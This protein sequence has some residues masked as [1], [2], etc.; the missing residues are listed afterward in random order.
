[1]ERYGM[2]APPKTYG[3][4]IAINQKRKIC[5]LGAL[6]IILKI[7]GNTE[8]REAQAESYTTS[9]SVLRRRAA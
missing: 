3:R 5:V 2:R 1:M 8:A 9:Y 7:P 4:L 6:T